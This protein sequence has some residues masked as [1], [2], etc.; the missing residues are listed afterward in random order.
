MITPL[1]EAARCRAC[2]PRR[3]VWLFLGVGLSTLIACSV[4]AFQSAS[5]HYLL[6]VGQQFT[7]AGRQLL[8]ISPDGKKFVYVANTRL[9]V[10]DAAEKDARPL[11]DSSDGV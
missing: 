6:P 9:Y 3:V 10:K 1:L 4:R 7:N 5:S 11:T 2:A 8:T